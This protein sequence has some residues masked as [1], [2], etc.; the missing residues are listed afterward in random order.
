MFFTPSA[1]P[2]PHFFFRPKMINTTSREPKHFRNVCVL[3]LAVKNGRF[4]GMRGATCRLAARYHGY[5][6]RDGRGGV[7]VGDTA[8]TSSDIYVELY[9][10]EVHE[11]RDFIRGV[12]RI[13]RLPEPIA[14]SSSHEPQISYEISEA[15]VDVF[16]AIGRRD[17]VRVQ[18]TYTTGNRRA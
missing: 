10:L 18:Q 4:P 17:R 3:K 15:S 9:F 14:K 11:T 1:P 6:L 8:E 16:A 13:H 2:H 7:A 5:Q 12:E